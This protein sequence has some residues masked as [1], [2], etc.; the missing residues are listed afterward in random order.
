MS[1]HS[2]WA[3]VK[4]KKALTDAKKGKLFSKVIREIMVAVRE[5]GP[6]PDSNPRLRAALDKAKSA[7][8]PKENVERAIERTTGE[9][10]SA[11][12]QEFLYEATADKGAYILIA[13]ITDNRNRALADI[14]Q[15]LQKHAAKL[16]DPGSVLWSFD[17]VGVLE[18]HKDKNEPKSVEEVEYLFIDAGAQNIESGDDIW[19]ITTTFGKQDQIKKIL[20][21]QGVAVERTETDYLPKTPIVLKEVGQS[22]VEGLQKE[23]LDLDDVQE[24]YT[25]LKK[26]LLI[27][28]NL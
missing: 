23:L 3:Q 9:G 1:G 21:D 4:H 16:A 28:T 19:I 20:E 25:N 2:R 13:G 27:Q 5:S 15:V 6:S 26:P 12:L 24:V 22:E 17:R 14:K 11:K 10:D 7:G 8:L 18:V